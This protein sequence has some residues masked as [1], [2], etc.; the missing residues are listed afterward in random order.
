MLHKAHV[1]GIETTGDRLTQQTP[2]CR[3]CE[4]G[5]T[6]RNCVMGP[7]R[8]SAKAAP[9]GKRSRGVCGT[10]AHVIVARN[11]GRF[12]AGGSA[13]H[14]DHGRDVIETLEAV[15]EG[16]A[17]GYEIRDPAKLLRIAGE[18]A[19]PWT[20]LPSPRWLLLSSTPVTPLLWGRSDVD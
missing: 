2:H 11:F 1:E 9:G 19:S 13:G 8:I 12:I 3:F 18:L 4:L 10:D 16:K 20:A 15:V 17:E 6:C 5:T 7:C 14:S